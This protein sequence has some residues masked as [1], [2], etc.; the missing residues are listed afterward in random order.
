[1]GKGIKKTLL[2]DQETIDILKIYGTKHTGSENI[3]SA[4]RTMA[5]EYKNVNRVLLEQ[6]KMEF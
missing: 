1:M 6:N 5:R 3:S 2:L 4:V